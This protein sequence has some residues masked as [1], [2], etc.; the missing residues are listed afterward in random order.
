MSARLRFITAMRHRAPAEGITRW[1]N[2]LA[3]KLGYAERTVSGWYYGEHEP[4]LSQ[5]D[6]L[7]E[8]LGDEVIDEVYPRREVKS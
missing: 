8:I 6:D 7:R 4:N 2:D 1:I 5:L 3:H